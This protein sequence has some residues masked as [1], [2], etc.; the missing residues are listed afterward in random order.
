MTE[1]HFWLIIQKSFD[2]CSGKT[3]EQAGTLAKELRKLLPDEIAAFAHHVGVYHRQ[4][5]SW[6]LWG[7]A[8]LINGGCSDDGFAD[9]R[10]WLISRG[11]DWYQQALINPDSLAD[12]PGLEF[13]SASFEEFAYVASQVHEKLAGDLP[14]SCL[15]LDPDEPVGTAWPE[16]DEKIFRT[17][18]PKLFA[19]FP[20]A[21]KGAAPAPWFK[22]II[23]LVFPGNRDRPDRR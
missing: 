20:I 21:E 10:S 9:F 1:E 7:A 12:Y 15:S 16:D 23:S 18:W 11:K 4:A 19:Q 17:R 2:A 3:D 22:R 5:Y 13:R 8:Y 14:E 6:E